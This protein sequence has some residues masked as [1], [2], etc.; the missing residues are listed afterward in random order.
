MIMIREGY[1][2]WSW[3]GRIIINQ[4]PK[5]PWYSK[6]LISLDQRLSVRDQNVSDPKC[7][8]IWDAQNLMSYILNCRHFEGE[9]RANFLRQCSPNR[10]KVWSWLA[11][12]R[13]GKKHFEKIFELPFCISAISSQFCITL[14]SCR[15]CMM[16]RDMIVTLSFDEVCPTP[17]THSLRY[18]C[19]VFIESF[20]SLWNTVS[21]YTHR[22]CPSIC[23]YVLFRNESFYGPS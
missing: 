9:Q 22:I 1:R 4:D 2:S 10:H 3:I 18:F 19:S 12:M 17:T 20:A 14:R 16:C 23:A 8:W 13:L 5:K 15:A 21:L 7:F 11:M 6:V